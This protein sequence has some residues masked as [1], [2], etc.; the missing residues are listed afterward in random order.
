[1]F[2][3]TANSGKTKANDKVMVKPFPQ[4]KWDR[5]NPLSN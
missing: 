2:G 1:V 3:P 4:L 5:E